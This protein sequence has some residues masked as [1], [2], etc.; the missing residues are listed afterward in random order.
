MCHGDQL[1]VMLQDVQERVSHD[2]GPRTRK[3]ISSNVTHLDVSVLCRKTSNRKCSFA[4]I[5]VKCRSVER[6]HFAK[7]D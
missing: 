1:A 5:L 4:T 3:S 6:A 7:K 2:E